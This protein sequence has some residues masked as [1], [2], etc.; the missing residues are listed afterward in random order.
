[1]A[2]IYDVAQTELVEKTAQELKKVDAI[3]SPEWASYVK[4]GAHKERVPSNPDWWYLRAASV[5]RVVYKLGPIGVS[6]L[7]GKY[8]GKRNRGVKPEKFYKASGNIIRKIL[9]Q[10]EKAELVRKEGKRIHKGRTITSKGVSLLNK[11]AAQIKSAKK[12][13]K[14]KTMDTSKTEE[15]PKKEDTK[16]E[17]KPAT[18]NPVKE[19]TPKPVEKGNDKK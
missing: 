17:K 5:L 16:Q 2:D 11:V 9:Q 19:A 13:T 10:L 6:K 18:Q 14:T 12:D 3:E 7:R 1:M 15:A 8:G 4:T